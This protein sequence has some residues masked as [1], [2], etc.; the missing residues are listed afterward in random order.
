MALLPYTVPASKHCSILERSM[1]KHN[2]LLRDSV[3]P[4][5]SVAIS[6]VFHLG[7]RREQR[8][9][10]TGEKEASAEGGTRVTQLEPLTGRASGCAPRAPAA[11]SPSSGAALSGGG[12][13]GR[14][15]QQLSA[16]Q[17]RWLLRES[18]VSDTSC[19]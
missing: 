13:A 18:A 4:S 17:R 2:S 8:E 9:N 15:L 3:K 10:K 1:F 5:T 11:S 12:R 6:H 19:E 7:K 16:A 14:V